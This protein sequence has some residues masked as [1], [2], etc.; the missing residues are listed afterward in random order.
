MS[1][2]YITYSLIVYYIMKK[3]FT[4]LEKFK[5]FQVKANSIATTI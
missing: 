2:F 1:N 3:S 5:T 4:L